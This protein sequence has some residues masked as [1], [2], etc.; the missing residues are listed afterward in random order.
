MVG[1]GFS[2]LQNMGLDYQ[3]AAIQ[4][5]GLQCLVKYSVMPWVCASLIAVPINKAKGVTELQVYH[6]GGET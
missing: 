3:R 2:A 4:E 6:H 5:I 1:L